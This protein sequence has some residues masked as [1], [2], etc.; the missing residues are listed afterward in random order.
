MLE[1]IQ[2][3]LCNLD[4]LVEVANSCDRA[5]AE[6]TG[7]PSWYAPFGAENP[8][9]VAQNLA[10]LQAVISGIGLINFN[11]RNQDESKVMDVLKDIAGDNLSTVEKEIMLRLANC[12]WGAGQ[13]FRTDKGPLGRAGNMNCFDLLDQTE[14]AKDY[15]QIKAASTWLLKKLLS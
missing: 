2:D 11:I 3:L 4:N 15:H 13:A 9:K 7:N 14:V 10:G 6:G 8:Q 5:Y 12:S 1:K